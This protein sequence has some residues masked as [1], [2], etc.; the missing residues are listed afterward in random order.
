MPP[1]APPTQAD[2]AAGPPPHE[3]FEDGLSA[4]LSKL[5]ELVSN[6]NGANTTPG[7]YDEEKHGELVRALGG[8]ELVDELKNTNGAH[9]AFILLQQASRQHAAYNAVMWATKT[10]DETV[11]HWASNT[12]VR[13][14]RWKGGRVRVACA[15]CL[16]P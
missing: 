6:Y 7:T 3:G 12:K 15:G 2:S 13:E 16:A 1:P 4:P 5:K 14:A 11:T 8:Q 9:K 10:E